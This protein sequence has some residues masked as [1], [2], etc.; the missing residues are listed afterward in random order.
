MFADHRIAVIIPALNEEQ[1][2]PHLLAAIPDWVDDVIVV[3]NGSS[4]ATAA[5][6]AEHGARV[7]SEPCRG[8]GAA[9]LA[10]IAASDAAE[11]LVFL[12]ADFSDH[13]EQMERLVSPIA[14]GRADLVIGSRT[15]GNRER[16]ALRFVQRWGNALA[17][18]LIRRF[19]SHNYTDLGPFRAIRASALA[20]LQMDDRNYGW[21]IQMQVRAVQAGLRVLEAPVDYRRR[22]GQSKISGTVRGVVSAGSK[23]LATVL[24]ERLR[25]SPGPSPRIAPEHLIV[26]SRC[27]EAGKTKTRLIPALGAEGAAALQQEMTVHTLLTV[28]QAQMARKASAEVRFAG[29]TADCMSVLFGMEMP[30]LPQGDGDLGQRMRRALADA[31]ARGAQRVVVIG[32]DCPSLDAEAIGDALNALQA[33]DCVLGPARDGGYYL[34]G[35]RSPTP[36]LFERIDWG[37]EQVLQQTLQRAAA[38]GLSVHRLQCRQDVDTPEDLAEWQRSR[39]PRLSVIIPALNEAATIRDTI[40]RAR[41]AESVE[42]LVVDGGSNDDTRRI[43]RKSGARVIRAATGRAS[44]MNAGAARARGELLVFLHA[45]TQLPAGYA[46]EVARTLSAPDTVVGAFRL[47]IAGTGTTFRAVEWGA[48]LRSRLLGMPY[49]DQALHMRAADFFRLGGFPALPIMEDFELVRRARRIGR[50]MTARSAVQTSARRWVAQG[51][52]RLTLIHQACVLAYR[53]GV[54]PARIAGWRDRNSSPVC[55]DCIR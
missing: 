32:S 54:A 11:I 34:V 39:R 48:S 52:L 24:R 19:W 6:A 29:G 55:G 51:V 40:E 15:L 53:L 28:N 14:R 13:P 17:C 36:G 37:G 21:T 30:L 31:F 35:L 18:L 10:G 44:Q 25:T 4:D 22:I 33:H 9:C 38:S 1:S 2:L 41:A 8:Y 7:V 42:V 50:V 20:S 3:D 43:A 5:V 26:F 27:P 49:G 23:I 12:D 46:D 16:G 45:D 47:H